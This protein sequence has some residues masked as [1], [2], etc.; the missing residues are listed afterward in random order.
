MLLQGWSAL[1][2]LFAEFIVQ[3]GGEYYSCV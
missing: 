3:F 1:H 2:L